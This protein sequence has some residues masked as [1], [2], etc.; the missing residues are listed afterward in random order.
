MLGDPT[1]VTDLHSGRLGRVHCLVP[2]FSSKQGRVHT[3]QQG[4]AGG[5]RTEKTAAS[6][7]RSKS[8]LV[9]RL[10]A[11]PDFLGGVGSAIS[12]QRG[13][14]PRAAGAATFSA[15]QLSALGGSHE[16]PRCTTKK[17]QMSVTAAH[18]C[19]ICRWRISIRCI[20]WRDHTNLPSAIW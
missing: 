16:L 2:C 3:Y 9:E 11:R 5:G 4:L 1:R 10:R 17:R 20:L 18:L 12:K 7:W 6:G 8:R 15:S 14:Q 13:R 19:I